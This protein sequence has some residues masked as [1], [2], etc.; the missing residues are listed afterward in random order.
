M[1]QPNGRAAF[2]DA[3]QRRYPQL[4]P[5][6]NPLQDALDNYQQME[7]ERNIAVEHA[8]TLVASNHA[9]LAEANMLR[10][11]L[12][13]AD[14]DRIRLQAISSTLL[15]RLFSIN[16]VVGGAVKAAIREGI[17]ASHA[18]KAEDEL[19][20]AGAEAQAIIQRV[21]PAAGPEVT[22]EPP[23]PPAPPQGVGAPI[24]GVDWSKLPQ[25]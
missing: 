21:A 14:S 9:L 15:G 8:R 10:E 2:Q 17:E 16:D 7:H 6:K 19:D 23:A 25:G 18:A 24:P 3:V 20:R 4:A 5:E 11:A 12:A 22:V 1:S 13:R